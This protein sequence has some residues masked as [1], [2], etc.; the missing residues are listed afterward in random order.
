M[1]K[2]YYPSEYGKFAGSGNSS[3]SGESGESGKSGYPGDSVDFCEVTDDS[4]DSGFTDDLGEFSD[5][6]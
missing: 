3:E 2:P 4:V 5:S 6:E 1:K